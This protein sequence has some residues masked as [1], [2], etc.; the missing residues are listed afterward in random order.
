LKI[1]T[2][3]AEIIE[4]LIEKNF[5]CDVTTYRGWSKILGVRISR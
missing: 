2:K 5:R 4:P 3:P 1:H